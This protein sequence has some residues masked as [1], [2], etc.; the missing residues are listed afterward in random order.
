MES[1]GLTLW[2]ATDDRLE[3]R[4][5]DTPGND[6][7]R[8]PGAFAAELAL[9]LARLEE[10]DLADGSL[11]LALSVSTWLRS[12]GIGI[13]RARPAMFALRRSLIATTALDGASEPVPLAAGDPVTA[14][15]G[16]A[17]YLWEMINRAAG[18]GA[19][20]AARVAASAVDGLEPLEEARTG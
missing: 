1:M 14:V 6:A 8:G 16:L 18:V 3:D 9:G 11:V 13:S 12:A 20:S 17:R 2:R 19:T 15:L 7:P 5:S 10:D 4:S